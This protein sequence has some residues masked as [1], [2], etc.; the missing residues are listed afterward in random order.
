MTVPPALLLVGHGQP[1]DPGPAGRAL[2]RLADEVARH[3]PGTPVRAATLAEPGA[4]PRGLA[5]PPGRILPMFMACGWFTETHLPARLAEASPQAGDWHLLPPL[6]CHPAL[7]DLAVTLAAEARAAGARALILAAHG[8]GRSPM[9]GRIADHVA[10][11][12]RRE[13]G[14]D[15]CEAAYLDHAPRLAAATGWPDPT[16]CLPWFA[17]GGAHVA[18]DIPAALAEAGLSGPLLPAIGLDPRLPALIA[19][20]ASG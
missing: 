17:A 19:R 2:D 20:L 5:G 13:T 14:L 7:Q 12:I 15:R 16:A 10:G 11:R 4:L 3:L 1:S 6:G 9:P 8:S 18:R